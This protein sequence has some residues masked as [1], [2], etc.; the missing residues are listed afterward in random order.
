M[1][2]MFARWTQD[3][4]RSLIVL[5]FRLAA[6]QSQLDLGR[7]MKILN[8]RKQFKASRQ[9]F[10]QCRENDHKAPLS[11]TA[12]TQALKACANTRD[13]E[14]GVDIHQL[15]SARN[16]ENTY[17]LT[18]LIHLYSKARCRAFVSTLFACSAMW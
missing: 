10:D 9:L 8:D 4:C 6:T 7:R 13:L 1:Q 11:S 2:F 16:G 17:I 18:S 3:R 12:I 5:A 14:R 15:V